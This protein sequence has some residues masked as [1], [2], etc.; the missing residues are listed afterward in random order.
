[1][2]QLGSQVT[3]VAMPIAAVSYLHASEFQVGLLGAAQMAAFLL[4]GLPAGAIVDRLSRRRVMIW[5]NV[6][7]AALL[8]GIPALW[9]MGSLSVSGLVVVALLT[10]AC[11]VFFDVAYMSIVPSLVP[12]AQLSD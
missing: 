2:S 8:A 3:N 7:R 5:A 6:I 11:A 12:R 9:L 4:L 10:G 1:V